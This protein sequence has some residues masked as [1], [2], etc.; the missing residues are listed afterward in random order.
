MPTEG[1]LFVRV[2]TKGPPTDEILTEGSPTMVAC[3]NAFEFQAVT[4]GLAVCRG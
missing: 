2:P 1:T 4:R 3:V